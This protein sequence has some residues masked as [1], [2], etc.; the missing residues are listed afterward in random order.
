MIGR[1]TAT[2]HLPPDQPWD[3]R[4]RLRGASA[5]RFPS[6]GTASTVTSR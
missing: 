4:G 1:L 3:R 6:A 2:G 5:V